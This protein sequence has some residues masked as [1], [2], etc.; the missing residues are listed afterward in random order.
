M[1]NVAPIFKKGSKKDIG[2]YRPVSLTCHAGKIL[3]KILK[4]EIVKF[5]EDNKRITN[6]QH[7]FRNRKSCLANLLHFM[8]R[9]LEYVD[10]GEPVDVFFFDCRR[11]LTKFRMGGYC[12]SCMT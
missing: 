10:E 1:A 2:N 4:E 9:V 12:K 11:L 8:E 6:S 3:E 5:L 7:G